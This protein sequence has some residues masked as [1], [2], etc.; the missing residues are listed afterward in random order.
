MTHQPHLHL[1]AARARPHRDLVHLP[2]AAAPAGAASA[3]PAL[4]AAAGPTSA[5]LALPILPAFALPAAAAEAAGAAAVVAARVVL[6]PP[7]AGPQ[8]APELVH[9]ARPLFQVLQEKEK[10]KKVG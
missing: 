5:S 8:A 10:R 1:E 7:E 6:L 3:G 9:P 4:A 2:L